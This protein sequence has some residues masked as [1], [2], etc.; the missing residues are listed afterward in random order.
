MKNDSHILMVKSE[1]CG[2]VFAEANSLEYLILV[3]MLVGL[4]EYKIILMANYLK[5]VS[6]SK[7]G[8]YIIN[9]F[10]SK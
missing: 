2:V 8:N 9:L 3:M 10:K 4:V 5:F 6:V 1:A 7:V